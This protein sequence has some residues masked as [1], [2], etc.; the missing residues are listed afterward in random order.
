M[1]DIGDKCVSVHI[2][3]GGQSA[4]C[5]A[6]CLDWYGKHR[7]T[8]LFSNTNTEAP[9]LYEF[10][11]AIE[12]RFNI[13]IVRLNNDGQ[14]IWDVFDK[15]GVI[16]IR[17]GMSACKAS[18]EL[19][20]KPLAKYMKEHHDPEKTVIALGLSA[21]EPERQEKHYSRLAPYQVIYPLN[22]SPKL[23]DC[24]VISELDNLDLPIP[25]A[26]RKGYTHNNC[27]GGCVLAGLK[28]WAGLLE[29]YPDR[30]SW[31]EERERQWRSKGRDFTIL[32]DRSGGTTKP[33]TLENLRLDLAA[34][35]PSPGEFRSG[36]GCMIADGYTQMS[37]FEL[38]DE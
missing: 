25:D 19:K 1:I 18:L 14:S 6:R 28:Q 9:D 4:V 7:V 10:L 5:L 26:Y 31:H 33:Y 8:C 12:R 22:V 13:E 2:S 37:I 35:R 38:L 11:D 3:G 24:E 23:S 36:C 32:R 15:A 16:S 17:T 29:D 21:F 27:G 30:Y 20:H 34:G